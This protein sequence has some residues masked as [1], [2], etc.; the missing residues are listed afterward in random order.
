MVDIGYTMELRTHWGQVTTIV[1][2]REVV[3]ISEVR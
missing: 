2:S 1:R 3:R